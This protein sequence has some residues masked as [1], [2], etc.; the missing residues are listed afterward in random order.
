MQTDVSFDAPR[1]PSQC[2]S[3]C[4]AAFRYQHRHCAVNGCILEAEGG[5]GDDGRSIGGYSTADG[6]EVVICADCGRDMCKACAKRAGDDRDRCYECY[7]DVMAFAMDESA[8]AYSVYSAERNLIDALARMRKEPDVEQLHELR[9]SVRDVR[10][11]LEI[12]ERE[13]P[14]RIAHAVATP[15]PGVAA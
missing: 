10:R 1:D 6:S 15:L 5:G 2:Y 13:L 7:A 11:V 3:D 8:M 9:K 4:H 14:H 12:I